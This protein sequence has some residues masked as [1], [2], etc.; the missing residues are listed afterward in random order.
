MMFSFPVYGP[1]DLPIEV[2]STAFDTIIE[3]YGTFLTGPGRLLE[4]PSGG[5]RWYALLVRYNDEPG[6]TSTLRIVQDGT[7]T[8]A[9]TLINST[10]FDL[11]NVGKGVGGGARTWTSAPFQSDFTGDTIFQ[12]KRNTAGSAIQIKH[13][14][15]IVYD[16]FTS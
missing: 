12:V 16:K 13:I 2:S 4:H 14:E 15:V 7:T 3:D 11:P 10:D 9:V 6:S 1:G 5:E 8:S